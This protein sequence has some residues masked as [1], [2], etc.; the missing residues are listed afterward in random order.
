[1]L[2]PYT[3]VPHQMDKMQSFIDFIFND[4]WCKAPISGPFG[5]QLFDAN[6]ELHEVMETFFYDDSK[7]ADFFYGHVER[8][9]TLFAVLSPERWPRKFGH[10]DKW[11][12]CDNNPGVMPE[13]AG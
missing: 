12:L 13:K 5:L 8:I 2:F 4:V 10:G 1:M 7:G 3:F 11:K 9:Y 6:A